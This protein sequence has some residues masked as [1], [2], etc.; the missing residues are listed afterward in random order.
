MG[1]EDG[2]DP[3]GHKENFNGD[4]YVHYLDSGNSFLDANL[5]KNSSKW[6]F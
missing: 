4:G 2:K 5:Y 3:Q 6:T 1:G